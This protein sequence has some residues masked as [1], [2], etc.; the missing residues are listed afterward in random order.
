[1][2]DVACSF[3]GS[4]VVVFD[5]LEIFIER[6]KRIEFDFKNELRLHDI[7][8]SVIPKSNTA[9]YWDYLSLNWS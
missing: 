1:M 9:T 4:D 6:R 7:P 2:A 5:K 3:Q 8:V